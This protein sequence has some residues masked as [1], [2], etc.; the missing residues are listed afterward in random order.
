METRSWETPR[1][2]V[3]QRAG[4]E[5]C[6]LTACKTAGVQGLFPAAVTASATTVMRALHDWAPNLTA[7]STV[8]S[9]ATSTVS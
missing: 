6:V 5:E 1:L 9:A 4:A 3:L 7:S 8:A 2:I